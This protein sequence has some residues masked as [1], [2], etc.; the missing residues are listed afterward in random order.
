MLTVLFKGQFSIL[1]HMLDF[2]TIFICILNTSLLNLSPN[3]FSLLLRCTRTKH[4]PGQSPGGLIL[5]SNTFLSF[6][7]QG[8]Y[9]TSH[10]GTFLRTFFCHFHSILSRTALG[11]RH[12]PY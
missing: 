7:R 5:H 3:L 2:V 12:C 1:C 9:K 4:V 11:E 8:A 6:Y 10:L